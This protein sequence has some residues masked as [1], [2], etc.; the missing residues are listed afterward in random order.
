MIARVEFRAEQFAADG[1]LIVRKLLDDREISIIRESLTNDPEIRAHMF[2]PEDESGARTG[3]A[4]WNHPG[5]S[6]Y[7]LL[8]R[9]EPVV[10]VF[11]SMLGGEVYHYHSKLTAKAAC[12]GGAWEWH[13]DYDYWYG[14]GCPEP[15]MG[16]VMVAVD[17]ADR[18]NG[19][20]QVIRGSHEQGLLPHDAIGTQRGVDELTVRKL[21]ADHDHIYVELDAG[22]AVFFHCNTVH[23]SDANRSP[24]RRWSLLSCYNAA[25]NAS[26]EAIVHPGYTPLLKVS[27]DEIRRTGVRF[28]DGVAEDFLNRPKSVG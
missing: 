3:I 13:Q 4:V 8:A 22:D 25:S 26:P 28:A 23:R 18:D 24:R 2:M 14:F 20:L 5:N 1:F 19:C 27:G 10:S 6:S 21:L 12:T 11:E 17:K 7:G 15:R 16:S 9:S